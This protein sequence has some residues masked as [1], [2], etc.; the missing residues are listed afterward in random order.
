MKAESWCDVARGKF[1]LIPSFE[2]GD[3]DDEPRN[4]CGLYNLE[5]QEYR[6]P[7]RIF[8]RN[9]VLPTLGI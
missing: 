2:D 3:R 1:H 9:T 8:R 6:F 4:V 7:A 5:R